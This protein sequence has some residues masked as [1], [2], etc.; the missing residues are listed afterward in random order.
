MEALELSGLLLS[1]GPMLLH[2]AVAQLRFE[3]CTLDPNSSSTASLICAD[4]N[5]RNRAD[6]ILCR[7]ITGGI[8]LGPGVER[9]TLA[10]SI[11]HQR[12]GLAISS[13]TGSPPAFLSAANVQL[14]RVTV[15]GL[16]RCEVL[17][18]S[19]CLLSD[20]AFVAD[21]QSG[22]VRF[23]RFQ[24][25]SV[26]PRRYRCVPTESQTKA[27]SEPWLCAVPVFNSRRFGRPDYAQLASACPAEILTAGESGAEVGAF[28]AR[29]NTIRFNNL[30][31]KLRE[32]LP[33]GLS[34]VVVAET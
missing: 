18:T 2:N 26:L 19:E 9:L 12:S 7:C 6:Y 20:L 33:V 14:E 13:G 32:F 17:S 10:D 28:A 29:L 23:T 25:G 3:A 27:S 30:Q 16:I 31:T 5:A 1:G 15:F 34:A 21:Q 8:V 22:C 11:V 24:R 4:N